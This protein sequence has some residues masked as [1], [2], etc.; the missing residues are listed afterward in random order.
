MIDGALGIDLD[1]SGVRAALA[2]AAGAPVGAAAVP[3]D[4]AA[5]RQPALLWA[6][7]AAALDGLAGRLGAVRR[8]AVDGTSGTILPIDAAGAA[9][10][11]LS[12]YKDAASKAAVAAVAAVMPGDSADGGATSPLARALDLQRD[13]AAHV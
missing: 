9:T 4:A 8:I 1:T 2:T 10:G 11:A 6:A 13:G 7:V 12:L 3:L 5:R